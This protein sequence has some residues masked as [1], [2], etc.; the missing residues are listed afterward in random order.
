[1]LWSR[2]Q[3]AVNVVMDSSQEKRKVMPNGIK[4][5]QLVHEVWGVC[6]TGQS[7]CRYWRRKRD[8]FV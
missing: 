8:C 6:L 3:G 7:G 4:Q 1:M 2:L 5:V